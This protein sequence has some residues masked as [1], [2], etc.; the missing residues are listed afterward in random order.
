MNLNLV[1]KLFILLL[2]FGTFFCFKKIIFADVVDDCIKNYPNDTTVCMQMLTKQIAELEQSMTPLKKES[3]GLQSKITS[4]KVQIVQME[5]Q[6]ADLSQQLINKEADLEV[7]QTLLSARV[8]RYYINTKKFSPLLVFFSSTESSSLLRQYTWY[9]AIISQDKN[10]ITGYVGDINNLNTNKVILES[11]KIKLATLKTSLESRFG[12]LSG[13]IKKA[14]DYKGKLNNKLKELEAQRIAKLNL[15]TSASSGISCVDDRTRDPGFGAGFAFFT[16]GIPHHVGLNQYGALGRAKAGQSAED[17]IKAYYQN[18]EIAG[19]REGQ[20]VKVNGKNE[21]GQ[22]FNNET[23]NIEEYLKHIY[24]MPTSWPEAALQA[25]AM[26]A[27][28]Y[29]LRVYSEKGW[30]APSQADQVVKKELN[31]DRWITAV[32]ATR[33]KV[34]TSGGQPIKAWFASTAGGYT[35]TSGDV[36]GGETAWT[37]RM[38]DTTGD[39]NSFEDLMNKA[40]DKDSPCFYAAQ[41]YRSEYN[42]SAWLKPSEVADIVNVVLLY[43]KDSAIQSHLCYKDDSSHGCTDTWGSEKVK[44]ELKNRGVTPYN[45][46][47]SASVT[48]WDKSIGRT[49]NLSFYGDA[50]QVS[51]SGSTFKSIFNIRAPANISIVGQLFNVEKR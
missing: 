22:I 6:A 9:Q 19:G 27:R 38:R 34:I 7:Q 25:Q 51:I 11:Q 26:A 1:K 45:S 30:L 42:K 29:A 49:N 3:T 44:D 2:F 36:W 13:E 4:A 28:S 16:F 17:I 23:M 50:G 24:E 10:T 33:G 12:F 18:V 46:I 32:N 21:F 48:D 20:S 31:N 15:P 41:G 37:K 39:I 35:F 43:Q 47:S 40:Y 8:K 14:E 5:K